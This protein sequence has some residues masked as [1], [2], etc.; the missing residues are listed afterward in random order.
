MF[1]IYKHM[2]QEFE[3]RRSFTYAP[4]RGKIRYM[5]T[6]NNV[7]RLL[8]IS[9]HISSDFTQ[10]GTCRYKFSKRH[11]CTILGYLWKMVEGGF[12]VNNFLNFD[13][14]T[15]RL[16]VLANT[17]LYHRNLLLWISMKFWILVST[18]LGLIFQ[19]IHLFT[20]IHIQSWPKSKLGQV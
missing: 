4:M 17:K 1:H 12:Y 3:F 19:K 7:T 10:G 14:R 20:P 11:T 15:R 9:L 5:S 2:R 6:T 8:A 13:K 18:T 16:C